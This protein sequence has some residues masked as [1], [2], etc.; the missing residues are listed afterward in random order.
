MYHM[1]VKVKLQGKGL[2]IPEMSVCLL[3]GQWIVV[4]NMVVGICHHLGEPREV[5]VR[6]HMELKEE[7]EVKVYL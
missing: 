1:K 6:G 4:N 7:V 5:K 2:L 3:V